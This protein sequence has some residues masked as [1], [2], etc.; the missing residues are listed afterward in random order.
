LIAI[1]VA[2]ILKRVEKN[3]K[4]VEEKKVKKDQSILDA[5]LPR[6]NAKAISAEAQIFKKKNK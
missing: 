5:A 4:H 3:V 6:R 1:L 2:K